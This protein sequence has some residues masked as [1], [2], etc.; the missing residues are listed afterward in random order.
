MKTGCW[1]SWE[2]KEMWLWRRSQKLQGKEGINT[3]ILREVNGEKKEVIAAR[4][5]KSSQIL[6]VSMF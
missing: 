4:L 5:G 6:H 3:V 2:G 1:G